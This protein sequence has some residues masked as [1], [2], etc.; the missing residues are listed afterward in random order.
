MSPD[1]EIWYKKLGK[2]SKNCTN[3]QKMFSGLVLTCKKRFDIIFTKK[4]T[5]VFPPE[6]AIHGGYHLYFLKDMCRRIPKPDI[7]IQ[8]K[9]CL[10]FLN[11]V[12]WKICLLPCRT[13]LIY[14]F[15]ILKSSRDAQNK[16]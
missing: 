9:T 4:I 6:W 8:K 1:S 14:F 12:S 3:S 2:C 7:K 11:Y 10:D 13:S 15:P 16:L 5:P